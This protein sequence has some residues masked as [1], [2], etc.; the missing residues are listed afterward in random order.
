LSCAPRSEV[1]EPSP[2]LRGRPSRKREGDIL[3]R[4]PSNGNTA[5]HPP[6][7]GRVEHQRGEGPARLPS[8]RLGSTLPEEE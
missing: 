1:E 4:V 7:C 2:A 5:C 3:Q 8:P 6:A